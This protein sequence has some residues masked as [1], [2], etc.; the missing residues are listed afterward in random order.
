MHD[1]SFFYLA[2]VDIRGCK[3]EVHELVCMFYPGIVYLFCNSGVLGL[4]SKINV[5]KTALPV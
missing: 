2:N 4:G 1:I 5:E 3:E